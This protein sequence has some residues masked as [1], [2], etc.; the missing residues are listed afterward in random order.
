M[1]REGAL[2]LLSDK[3][4]EVLFEYQAHGMNA[5]SSRSGRTIR[6]SFFVER[7]ILAPASLT[8]LHIAKGKGGMVPGSKNPHG[9]TVTAIITTLWAVMI[10]AALLTAYE[11]RWL[12]PRFA[13]IV[14]LFSLTLARFSLNLRSETCYQDF[15]G[16]NVCLELKALN[17]SDGGEKQG[18]IGGTLSGI[19]PLNIFIILRAQLVSSKFNFLEKYPNGL[20]VL[21]PSCIG[22]S[23]C[24]GVFTSACSLEYSVTTVGRFSTANSSSEKQVMIANMNMTTP[25]LCSTSPELCQP[26]D[27]FVQGSPLL[28]DEYDMYLSDIR[29]NELPICEVL[30]EDGDM[31]LTFVFLGGSF[32]FFEGVIRLKGSVLP[33]QRWISVGL[34]GLILLQDPF[35]VLKLYTGG[36]VG[37]L[38]ICCYSAALGIFL[39]FWLCMI[40]GLQRDSSDYVEE[41]GFYTSKVS[42]GIAFSIA[43]ISKLYISSFYSLSSWRWLPHVHNNTVLPSEKLDKL[44]EMGR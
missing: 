41:W 11:D 28:Y 4:A 9:D 29:I 43:T 22:V 31:E 33:E 10:V 15:L 21:P 12:R 26:L 36:I 3:T 35:L 20:H 40:H 39:A 2:P 32:M 24:N 44:S 30:G 7:L 17:C 6:S 5:L 34:F 1:R 14:L 8:S 25:I 38:S 19:K 37:F 42:F 16:N 13:P 23:R 27:L 18:Q